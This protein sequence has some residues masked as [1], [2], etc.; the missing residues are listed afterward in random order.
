MLI[1]LIPI[2]LSLTGGWLSARMGGHTTN[3]AKAGR[4]LSNPVVAYLRWPSVCLRGLAIH[5]AQAAVCH[6]R[7]LARLAC[8]NTTTLVLLNTA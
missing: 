3:D 1:N 5:A 4:A 2:V 8:K 6:A 7:A